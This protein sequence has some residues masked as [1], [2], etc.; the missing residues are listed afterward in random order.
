MF[1]KFPFLALLS[2]F[3]CLEASLQ[4]TALGQCELKVPAPVFHSDTIP[5]PPSQTA[6]WKTPATSLP[7]KFVTATATLF[8]QG[9]ADPR[10]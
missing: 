6:V 8:D 3:L 7:E 5:S 9:L 10:D 1:S 2:I 4:L